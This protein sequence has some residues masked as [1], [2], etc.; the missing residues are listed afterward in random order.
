MNYLDTYA[1]VEIREGNRR[2]QPILDEPFTVS[3]ITLAE[4]FGIELRDNGVGKAD[5]WINRLRPSSQPVNLEVL[6]KAV[7]FRRQNRTQNFS[8][9]DAVGYQQAI[10]YNGTFVTGDSAFK[11]LPHVKFIK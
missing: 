11:D 5:Q 10:H 3:E 7:Q 8:F 2:Y 6:L 9:F 4:F 1:L